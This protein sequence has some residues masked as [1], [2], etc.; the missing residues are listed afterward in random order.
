MKK[1]I[2]LQKP[3]STSIISSQFM[4]F[5]A[6]SFLL[7]SPTP[8]SFTYLLLSLAPCI[9]APPSLTCHRANH[10]S[11]FIG[12]ISLKHRGFFSSIR[13]LQLR[14]FS[15]SK[16]SIKM[17]QAGLSGPGIL[18]DI[19]PDILPNAPQHS[20]ILPKCLSQKSSF[21]F[22]CLPLPSRSLNIR[23]KKY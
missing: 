14:L 9:L 19:L 22:S 23:L 6:F 7:I 17:F 18:P 21:Y 12:H 5:P 4:H 10:G 11:S 15:Y 3:H 2:L 1:S 8:Q 20:V 13:E 16:C